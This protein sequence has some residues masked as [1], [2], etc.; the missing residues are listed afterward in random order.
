LAKKIASVLFLTTRTI[1]D[2]L[3]LYLTSIVLA[4]LMQCSMTLALFINEVNYYADLSRI[5]AKSNRLCGT[6]VCNWSSIL[7]AALR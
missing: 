7:A 6:I 4:E 5:I 3:R 1:S 2:G